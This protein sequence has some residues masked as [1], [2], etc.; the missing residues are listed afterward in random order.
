MVVSPWNHSHEQGS[1]STPGKPMI[2]SK[3]VVTKY[4]KALEKKRGWKQTLPLHLMPCNHNNRWF[5]VT[6]NPLWS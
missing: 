1:T 4:S 5:K 2:F 6:I 3:N